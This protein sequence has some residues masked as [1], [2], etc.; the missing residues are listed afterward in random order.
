[1]IYTSIGFPLKLSQ[2]EDRRFT[3]L[4]A[5]FIIWL[6][7]KVTDFKRPIKR[8]WVA[9]QKRTSKTLVFSFHKG[10][11]NEDQM[12][13]QESFIW[14]FSSPSTTSSIQLHLTG[15]FCPGE[16][17]AVSSFYFRQPLPSTTANW[18]GGI[19]PMRCPE[20]RWISGVVF[21][22]HM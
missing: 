5:S 12:T 7:N 4:R 2:G 17:T 10:G 8:M 20:G 14:F 3:T 19:I 16:R 1:M 11:C 9:E 15:K 6:A 18:M 13:T 22:G 21:S